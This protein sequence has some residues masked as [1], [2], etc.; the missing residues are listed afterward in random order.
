[1][2]A[3]HQLLKDVFSVSPN[4]VLAHRKELGLQA[5]LAIRPPN[6]SWT[7]KQHPKYSYKLK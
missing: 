1:M 4:T 3:Y 7:N 5:V 6:T 2:K